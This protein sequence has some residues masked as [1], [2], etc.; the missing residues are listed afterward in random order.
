I[1]RPRNA[2]IIYRQEKHRELV[3]GSTGPSIPNKEI[4][5]I[6]GKM[7]REEPKLVKDE[8]HRRAE[9]EKTTHATTYPDYKYSP[10][11]SIKNPKRLR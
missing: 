2:F 1:P 9:E 7:W 10:R 6:I 8:Y 3:A 5:K 4:S 11:K